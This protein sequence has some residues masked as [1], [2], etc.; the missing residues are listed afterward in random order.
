L[1]SRYGSGLSGLGVVPLTTKDILAKAASGDIKPDEA[2]KL[3][4]AVN[5]NGKGAQITAFPT[6]SLAVAT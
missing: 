2:A 3:F 4:A 1:A 6:L 5:G